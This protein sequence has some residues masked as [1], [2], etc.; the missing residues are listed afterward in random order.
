M[1]RADRNAVAL[2][3]CFAF[4]SGFVDAVGY[5]QLGGFFVSFMT[6]NSTRLGIDVAE[7]RASQIGIAGALIALFVFGVVLA[8][9]VRV[10]RPRAGYVAVLCLVTALLS[11]AT[12]LCA[13]G[14]PWPGIALITMAMGAEN[15]VFQRDGDVTI[16]LTYMTGTL[17]KCGQKI[18]T[19]FMGDAPFEWVRHFLLW[20]GVVIGAVG[21]GFA[22]LTLG[23]VGSLA[24]GAGV[25]ALLTLTAA[26]RGLPE[27]YAD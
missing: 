20:A 4:L 6:G 13:Y 23:L 9:F 24:C 8:A 27:R 12:A 5:L 15:L 2:A 19:A 10:L 14:S 3:M 18:A 16:G 17:V 11:A 26:T 1:T 22:Y 7:G 21:G 25:A